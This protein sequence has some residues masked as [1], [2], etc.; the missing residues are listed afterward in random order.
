MIHLAEGEWDGKSN[1]LWMYLYAHRRDTF[2]MASRTKQLLL[3]AEMRTRVSLLGKW[4][5]N[6]TSP[7]NSPNFPCVFH[8]PRF[9]SSTKESPKGNTVTEPA[10]CRLVL[11]LETGTRKRTCAS[12]II[13]HPRYGVPG[14]TLAMMGVVGDLGYPPSILHQVCPPTQPGPSHYSGV[15]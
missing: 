6:L 8:D 9:A 12:A 3:T 4:A 1:K 10:C 15:S 5:D 14:L 11:T 7:R 2:L 13:K